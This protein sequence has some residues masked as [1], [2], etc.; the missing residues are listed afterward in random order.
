MVDR[1]GDAFAE[2]FGLG[3]VPLGLLRGFGEE[4]AA[5]AEDDGEGHQVETTYFGMLLYLSA[6]SPS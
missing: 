2:G 4:V 3:Q 6:S 5:G 1:D